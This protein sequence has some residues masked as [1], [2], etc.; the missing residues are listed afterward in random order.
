MKDSLTIKILNIS[1]KR[2]YKFI[3]LRNSY[4][5]IENKPDYLDR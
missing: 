2:E 5:K 1:Q 3:E 4:W